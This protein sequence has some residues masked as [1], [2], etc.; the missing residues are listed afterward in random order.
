[1]QF[2]TSELWSDNCFNSHSKCSVSFQPHK[3]AHYAANSII[4]LEICVFEQTKC[5]PLH[6]VLDCSN[7]KVL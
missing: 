3:Q 5:K 2:L 6:T 1:M 7:Y 4:S